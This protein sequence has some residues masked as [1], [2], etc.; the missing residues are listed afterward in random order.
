M[1][2]VYISGFKKDGK[3]SKGLQS[4]NTIFSSERATRRKDHGA[5]IT[6][7][8]DKEIVMLDQAKEKFA[9]LWS[10]KVDLFTMTLAREPKL[11]KSMMQRAYDELELPDFDLDENLGE[12]Y[13]TSGEDQEGYLSLTPSHETEAVASQDRFCTGN[14]NQDQ[15]NVW[16]G[17]L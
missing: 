9:D 2:R 12:D 10:K 8:D 5:C 3:G 1:K 7:I 14:R 6:A 4:C 16:Y 11:S 17:V 15:Q 13:F